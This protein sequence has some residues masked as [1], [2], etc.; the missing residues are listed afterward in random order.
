M[1]EDLD[2]FSS[3][4]VMLWNILNV[5]QDSFYYILPPFCL[6]YKIWHVFVPQQFNGKRGAET[7]QMVRCNMRYEWVLAE[8]FLMERKLDV[9]DKFIEE[10]IL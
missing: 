1:P 4:P 5:T 3:V 7:D 9:P 8:R 6:S 2:F 10:T